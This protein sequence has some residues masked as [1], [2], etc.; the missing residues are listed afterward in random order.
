MTKLIWGDPAEK[1]YEDGLDRCVLYLY[2][3]GYAWNGVSSIEESF[4]NSE[5]EGL[6]LDGFKYGQVQRFPDYEAS[7]EA[8]SYPEQFKAC[9]GTAEFMPGFSAGSQPKQ[10]FDFSYRTLIR[11]EA[12][13]ELGYQL[14][15]VY[16]A[17]ANP[18]TVV[19]STLSD[20]QGLDPRRWTIT[21]NPVDL[22]SVTIGGYRPA[23]HFV[24]DSRTTPPEILSQIEDILYGTESTDP[25]II[26][27]AQIY[28]IYY[29]VVGT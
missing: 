22:I 2:G 19:M 16:N 5:F 15:L 12:D 6:F 25:S 26:Y 18:D 27:P 23:A 1:I 3:L 17:F 29:P 14:H 11:S 13:L 28:D 21:T 4:P 7:L 10:Q 24:F 9:E 8:Y 20:D